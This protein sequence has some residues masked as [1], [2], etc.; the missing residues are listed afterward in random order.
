MDTI[1]LSIVSTHK[2]LDITVD[3]TLK[4]HCHISKTVKKAAGLTN[5]LLNSTL[6]HD[7]DFMITLFKSHIRPLL[8][9]SS[10]VWNTGYLGN[11]KLLES[12]QRRWTKQIAGMTDL[13]Y[14]DRL[15]TLNLYSI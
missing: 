14:A 9:F 11:Q 12:T 5:N 10:I 8:E 7:K 15:Q 3:S 6:C 2:D 1:A 4:F 13:N